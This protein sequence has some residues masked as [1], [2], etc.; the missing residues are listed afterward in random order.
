MRSFLLC[1]AA[2]VGLAPALPAAAATKAPA[3]ATIVI[4]IPAPPSSSV[5]AAVRKA[6]K[7]VPDISMIVTGNR[8]ASSKP[9]PGVLNFAPGEV[10]QQMSAYVGRVVAIYPASLADGRKGHLI[11][12]EF[13]NNAGSASAVVQ[14]DTG[15]FTLHEGERVI[16]VRSGARMRVLPYKGPKLSS[17]H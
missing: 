14:P 9:L 17:K 13:A 15:A 10:N 11:V 12:L 3:A 16:V 8:S 4:T 1:C 7:N 5:I 6:M 2:A